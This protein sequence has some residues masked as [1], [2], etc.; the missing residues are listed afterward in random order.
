MMKNQHRNYAILAALAVLLFADAAFA[1]NF[2]GG[3]G[4][5]FTTGLGGGIDSVIKLVV[6]AARVVGIAGGLIHAVRNGLAWQKGDR[7][8]MD[9][10][11]GIV[12][13][14]VIIGASQGIAQTILNTVAG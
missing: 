10:L 3:N 13:G 8:A 7:D 12:I 1:Q 4:A 14:F 9:S 6:N 11:K 5:T 2:N